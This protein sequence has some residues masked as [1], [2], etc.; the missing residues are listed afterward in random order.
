MSRQ[1]EACQS[2]HIAG[3]SRER[4]IMDV[5]TMMII[6][7]VAVLILFGLIGGGLM[8]FWFGAL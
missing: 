4:T 7:T 3:S 8:D 5:K 1:A 6:A 2:K